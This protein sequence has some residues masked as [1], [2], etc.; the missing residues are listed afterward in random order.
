MTRDDKKNDDFGPSSSRSFLQAQ[1]MII[2]CAFQKN[3]DFSGSFHTIYGFELPGLIKK[4]DNL[5]ILGCFWSSD[6]LLEHNNWNSFGLTYLSH[7]SQ[8]DDHRIE[9]SIVQSDMQPNLFFDDI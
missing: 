8:Y 1:V 6:V 5:C 4:S 3:W 9:F 7:H 2:S